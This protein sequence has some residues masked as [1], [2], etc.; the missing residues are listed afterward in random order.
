MPQLNALHLFTTNLCWRNELAV[1]NTHLYSF[2]S[3]NTPTYLT[4]V[5]VLYPLP[6]VKLVYFQKYHPWPLVVKCGRYIYELIILNSPHPLALT[7]IFLFLKLY[8]N[9]MIFCFLQLLFFPSWSVFL[10]YCS[11]VCSQVYS[12]S[13]PPLT[14]LRNILL[15]LVYYKY[16]VKF[17]H[18]Y[19]Y[20]IH[21]LLMKKLR[22]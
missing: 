15:L 18:F 22:Y 20:I 2:T 16:Y 9:L 13:S 19:Y 1:V 5:F 3:I 21:I 4:L 12:P 11:T 6:T 17:S 8:S 10:A 7:T 14:L